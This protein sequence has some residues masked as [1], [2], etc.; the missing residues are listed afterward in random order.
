MEEKRQLT[1]AFDEVE[2][3]SPSNEKPSCGFLQLSIV[4]VPVLSLFE[5]A[6]VVLITDLVL[7]YFIRQWPIVRNFCRCWFLRKVAHVG[8]KGILTR[9][10]FET[11]Q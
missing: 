11:F 9:Y 4:L 1:G 6:V 2:A 3:R 5:D 7:F 10:W 8:N